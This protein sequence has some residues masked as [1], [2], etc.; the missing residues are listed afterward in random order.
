MTLEQQL[1][2]AIEYKSPKQI[3]VSVSVLPAAFARYGDELT[4]LLKEYPDLYGGA[5]SLSDVTLP[6][7]YH[8]GRHVDE[9]GCVWEN[10]KE[11]MEAIVTGHPVP[12]R[13]D[14]YDLQIPSNRDGRLPH[15]FMYLRLLDLRGFEEAMTDF[16]EECPE[17]QILI[18]KVLT[19]NMYQLEAILPQCGQMLFFGDD[20]GMQTGLAIG[21]ERWRK[22]LKPCYSRLYG[23]VRETGRYVYM[24][25]DGRI[26]EIMP[27]LQE[28]GVSMINPQV[29]ANGLD[30]LERVCK[31]KIPIL[32]DLDR[33]FIP[34]ATP[35]QITDHV[36]ECVE[37]LWLPEG[38]LA[39]GLELNYETSLEN[40]AA[41]LD[42]LRK[43]RG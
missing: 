19:Y 10:V 9:W 14:I 17:L 31:G 1:I 13:E 7:S 30:N 25:T 18:D 27:D 21:A 40:M 43:F 16:A 24:H 15:G 33:Q 37:R 35:S 5:T 4:R 34:F 22:Y 3:P 32:L 38:G 20:Q 39:L 8:E 36:R 11:G 23:R 12:N 41:A 29:G 28:C 2:C 6:P 42:A 26:F